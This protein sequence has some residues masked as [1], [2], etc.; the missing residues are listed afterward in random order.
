MRE[1]RKFR[2]RIQLVFHDPASSL[3]PRKCIRD[4]L[5]QPLIHL[6]GTR[7][8]PLQEKIMAEILAKTDLPSDTLDRFPHEFSGGQAQCICIAQALAAKPKVLVLDEAVSALDVSVQAQILRLLHRLRTE[9]RLTL[10]FI[11][12]DLGVV[13]E[14][15]T[16]VAVLQGGHLVEHG[17]AA[18]VFDR[19]KTGYIRE[20]LASRPAGFDSGA[21]IHPPE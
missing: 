2:R 11:S 20:L 14:L 8:R 18:E 16:H 13:R 5:R 9:E 10:L 1:P 12:H 17:L 6:A 4:I 21:E 7:E 19:P 15:C 3:N